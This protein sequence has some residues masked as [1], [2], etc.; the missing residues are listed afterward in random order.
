MDFS[1][2]IDKVAFDKF[3]L[4]EQSKLEKE[5][6]LSTKLKYQSCMN[7]KNAFETSINDIIKNNKRESKIRFEQNNSVNFED[8]VFDKDVKELKNLVLEKS[9]LTLEISVEHIAP[10]PPSLEFENELKIIL[11]P[12]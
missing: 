4:K 2:N 7:L 11:K 6:L 5:K 12:K 10:Y 8:C 9:N 1:L 3:L